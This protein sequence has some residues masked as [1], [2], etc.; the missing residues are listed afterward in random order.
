M[1][2]LITL[3]LFPTLLLWL[4]A[5]RSS[6]KITYIRTLQEHGAVEH[7]TIVAFLGVCLFALLAARRSEGR[8]RVFLL[9]IALF[10]FWAAGEEA[11]WGQHL[12]GFSS[13]HWFHKYNGQFE[14]N[15]HNIFQKATHVRFKL[16]SAIAVFTGGVFAP[17]LAMRWRRFRELLEQFGVNL[18]PRRFTPVLLVTTLLFADR[19]TGHEEELAECFA[20]LVVMLWMILEADPARAR[21]EGQH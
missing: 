11:S 3:L 4:A 1:V 14:T 7:L 16:V 6:S 15:F 8:R 20:A 19:P 2:S 13:P 12:L 9:T 10:G 17:W 18:P 21:R 5:V